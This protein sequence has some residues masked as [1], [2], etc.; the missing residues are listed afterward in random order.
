M[1]GEDRTGIA[2][3][4][5][6]DGWLPEGLLMIERT[7]VKV[8][9]IWLAVVT[10]YNNITVKNIQTGGRCEPFSVI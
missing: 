5:S 2:S 8:T 1:C 3:V 4:G 7:R 6:G 10:N 9:K